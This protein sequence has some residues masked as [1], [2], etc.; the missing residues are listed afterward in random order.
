[1][2]VQIDQGNRT[3]II[4]ARVGSKGV[5][6]KNIK[7]L[8]GYPLIAYS[9][10]LA[11]YSQQI[12]RVIVSTDSEEIAEIARKYG[13]EVPFLR[14]KKYAEDCSGDIEFI[15]HALHWF[16][17]NE[18]S[19]PEYLIHLRPTTPLRE[20]EIV[21]TAISTIMKREEATSLRSAHLASE[22]PYKWF[23]KNE[24]EYFTALS[25]KITL[26]EANEGRQGFPNVYIPDGYV[27]VLKSQFIIE[28]QLLH[29]DRMI[30]FE[31]PCCYEVDTIE[32]FSYLEYKI[33][34]QGSWIYDVLTK[35]D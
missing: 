9:I 2:T 3:A 28:Q 22:S 15:N 25:E 26:D 27:D 16:M 14:P 1:M 29:G 12:D 33:K 34:Q 10:I 5:P 23:L 19:V 8:Q 13:A 31:S 21:D 32:D 6:Q 11:R 4:P 18:G 35:L 17:D 7:L 20:V 24:N 30:A